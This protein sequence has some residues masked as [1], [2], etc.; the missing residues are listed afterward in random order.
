MPSIGTEL[1]KHL[2]LPG[3]LS[4]QLPDSG[5]RVL[6][7]QPGEILEG[8]SAPGGPEQ[9]Q[10]GDSIS[11]IVQS[12]CQGQKI[13]NDGSVNQRIDILSLVAQIIVLQ[14]RDNRFEMTPGTHQNSHRTIRIILLRLPDQLNNPSCLIVVLSIDVTMGR[15]QWTISRGIKCD[16]RRETNG[17][18]EF[19][20]VRREEAGEVI[21]D[22]INE[23]CLRTKVRIQ[24]NT[25]NRKIVETAFA[26]TQV[27]T[28]LCLSK[29]INRLHGV[30][31][32]KK[33]TTITRF[34]ASS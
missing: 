3:G 5:T 18:T 32:K 2:Y 19:V 25:F 10:P 31:D 22:P 15:N 13:L 30:A 16:R 9:R 17:A 20:F 1:L 14:G 6:T 34:P 24:N 23:F 29:A 11:M 26:N 12:P 4:Q 28:N 33:R 21:V 8:K 7:T 27:E